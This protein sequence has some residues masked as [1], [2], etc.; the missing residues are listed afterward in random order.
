MPYGSLA[1]VAQ[2]AFSFLLPGLSSAVRSF[3]GAGRNGIVSTPQ[4]VT[5]F[6]LLHFAYC[7]L[8][9]LCSALLFSIIQTHIRN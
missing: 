6:R 1:D 7:M 2:T 8:T 4:L 3:T 5:A 9:G